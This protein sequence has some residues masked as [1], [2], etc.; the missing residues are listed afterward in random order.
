A[1]RRSS[2]EGAG[3]SHAC[4]ARRRHDPRVGGRLLR[5]PRRRPRLRRAGCPGPASRRGPPDRHPDAD[6]RRRRPPPPGARRAPRPRVARMKVAILGGTGSFGRA[7]AVR[8][9]AAGGDEIVIGSRDESRA[10]SAAAEL[11]HGVAGATN[12][13]AVAAVELAVLAVKA[14]GALDTAGE[15]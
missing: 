8:L 11:G 4:A 12:E 15:I 13:R 10:R 7:L 9:V 5:G 14:E 2:S 1:D 6:G 3:G